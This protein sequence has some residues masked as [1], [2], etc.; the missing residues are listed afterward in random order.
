MIIRQYEHKYSNFKDG[1]YV[2]DLT[3][4]QIKAIDQLYAM[5]TVA[6]LKNALRGVVLEDFQTVLASVAYVSKKFL[7]GADTGLGKSLIIWLYLKIHKMKGTMKKALL[8][9]PNASVHQLI[10][11]GMNTTDLK[12]KYLSGEQNELMAALADPKLL[13]YDV[14][15]VAHSVFSKSTEFARM[16]IRL[17]ELVNVFVLDESMEIANN[18][19]I[20]HKSIKAWVRTCEWRLFANAT[21]IEK[22]I[23]Q[24][25]NQFLVLD[26][27]LLPSLD[28]LKERHEKWGKDEKGRRKVVGYKNVDKLLDAM[29]YHYRNISR[30]AIGKMAESEDIL[31]P[32]RMTSLQ[33]QVATPNNYWF[34]LFSPTTQKETSV[35]PFT[36]D[37]VPALS[38]L[39]SVVD[40]ALKDGPVVIFA[41]PTACKEVIR[42][43]LESYNPR[44][45]VGIIDGLT[46]DQD[47]T[48]DLFNTGRLD[49]VIINIPDA[50]DLF[51]GKSIIFYTIPSQHYQARGRIARSIGEIK[52]KYYYLVYL[53]S[54]QARYVKTTL[55]KD[56]ETLDNALKRGF[57]PARELAN[58]IVRLEKA[59]LE[60]VLL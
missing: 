12:I 17:R 28:T 51:N 7:V 54:Y 21:V 43:E 5:G 29:P 53:H 27:K 18:T 41:E 14:Y 8:T 2:S 13:E 36:R 56:E 26:E 23:E 6:P 48:R 50:L 19:S 31:V 24:L 30:M 42:K 3:E 55:V 38:K 47:Y 4:G 37:E 9:T 58:K 25:Y 1:R 46:V 60:N 39:I 32:I 35:I 16:F 20:V 10:K 33:E 57:R 52:V 15:V 45:R 49:I 40:L 34:A 59:D 22:S 11:V 44:L